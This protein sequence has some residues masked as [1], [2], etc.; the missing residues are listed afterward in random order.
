MGG[1]HECERDADCAAGLD[2]YVAEL[3]APREMQARTLVEAVCDESTCSERS[4]CKCVFTTPPNDL[5]EVNAESIT[6]GLD[7]TCDA[8]GRANECL[9]PAAEFAGCSADD[10]CSCA[11]ACETALS[12][13]ADDAARELD[14]EARS[15]RCVGYTC[16]RLLRIEERCQVLWDGGDDTSYDCA[17]SDDEIFRQALPPPPDAGSAPNCVSGCDAGSASAASAT[18]SPSYSRCA[19]SVG[20]CSNCYADAS[21]LECGD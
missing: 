1:N 8:R 14:V 20:V 12:R 5:G 19:V 7:R 2:A 21:A 15:A 9:L 17:L 3:R 18:T 10:A 13:I 16:R 4:F 6:V 11:P